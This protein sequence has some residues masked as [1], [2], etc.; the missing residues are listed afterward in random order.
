MYLL[1]AGRPIY[2][3]LI[4]DLL[5]TGV[6]LGDVL[7]TDGLESPP[8]GGE[9]GQLSGGTYAFAGSAARFGD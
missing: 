5:L 3:T 1:S 4:V 8:T 6:P 7:P 2:I 9:V